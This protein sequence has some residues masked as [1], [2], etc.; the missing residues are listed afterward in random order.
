MVNKNKAKGSAYEQRIANRL[1]NEF[2]KNLEEYPYQ[3]QLST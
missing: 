1:T 2:K 3:D